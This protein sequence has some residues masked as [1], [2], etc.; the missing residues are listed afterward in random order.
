MKT[1]F[2]AYFI[3]MTY[4]F[5]NILYAEEITF[6][7]NIKYKKNE[8]TEFIELKAQQNL[9]LKAGDRALIHTPDGI[10]FLIFSAR[11]S[12]S[13]M[14]ISKSQISLAALEQVT[15]FLEKTT[16]DIIDGVRKVDNLISKRNYSLA[17]TTITAL[18]EKYKG[19]STILFLSGTTNYLN[20]NKQAALK[21][22]E[23]GLAINPENS[24]AKKLLEKIKKEL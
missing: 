12:D 18:K 19:L 5:S 8:A 4:T 3:F 23:S 22:L 11:N 16:S 20:N 17:L 10:P 13:K 9:S 14:N 2:K 7:S 6:D 15:P 1:L 24:S 21:D